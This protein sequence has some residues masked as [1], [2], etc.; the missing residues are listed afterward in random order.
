MKVSSSARPNTLGGPQRHRVTEPRGLLCVSES[1]WPVWVIAAGYLILH[2]PFLAPNLEDV[3]SINFALGLRD[4]DPGR[5]QPHPPGYPVY[6]ALGRVSLFLISGIWSTLA[7]TVAEATA[8]ALWSAFGGAVAIVALFHVFRALELEGGVP[9]RSLGA[10][11]ATGLAA[12]AP[13]FW[14]S[15]LRP[16]SDMPGLALA[17]SAQALILSGRTNRTHLALGACLAGLALGLRV[18]TMWLTMPLLAL[19]LVQQRQAGVSWLL[20]RPVAALAA[21]VV[22]WAVPLLAMS[23]GI[24]GYL[25]A[26]GTQADED[27]AW[28]NM[29]WLNPTPRRLAFALYETFVQ[30]WAA[31]PLSVAVA[32]A[33]IA[34]ALV[35]LVRERRV[36]LLLLLAF[37]PYALFHLLFQDTVFVRYALPT[38][39]MVAFLAVRGVAIA[40]RFA[41]MMAVPLVAASLVVA[42]PGS[43]AY[44]GESHPAFRAIAEASRKSESIRPAAVFSHFAIW[45]AV[46]AE[47]GGL[48]VTEPRRQFEW[49]ALVDYWAGG[50]TEPVWFL[51]DARRTD[52]ALIDPQSSRD[53]VRYRWSVANRPELSGTRPMGVDWYRFERPGWFAGQGWSLTAEA[54][55]LARATATGPDH[56]PIEAWVRRRP[57]PMHLVVGGRH[58]GDPGDPAAVF[59]LAVDGQVRDR[60]TVTVEERNFLRFLDLP[61]GIESGDGAYARLTIASR[62]TGTGDRRAAV[63]VR[64]FDIQ[65]AQDMVYGLG[66]GWHEE[67]YD[68]PSGRRWRWTSEKSV[69]QTKGPPQAVRVTLR[70]EDPLKYFDAPPT[71]RLTAGGRVIGELRP[72]ADFDWSVTVPAEDVARGLGA[73]AIETDRVYLPGAAEGTADER[74]LALRLFEWGVYPVAD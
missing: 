18:Q 29:V 58:L 50:G 65:P 31:L 69:I 71:V 55:G 16:M 10:G 8:L 20:T 24:D 36:L 61:D 17:L 74:H 72:A 12:A 62:A 25:R 34:G 30:P 52:L 14:I 64:Q 40:G 3:D 66:D 67:E 21:G 15:G 46:Q 38:I 28:V 42:V 60:W 70:G 23:G 4:F 63:A 32:A 13:V 39:P 48:P 1:L 7:Q 33:A 35:L 51:A 5:H 49:L 57:G 2:L 47:N 45:R 26:L 59:E 73:I 9:R 6:I 53:V 19:A 22:A 37:A 11:W 54:G 56:R 41:P 44:G 68:F 43:V 27:F